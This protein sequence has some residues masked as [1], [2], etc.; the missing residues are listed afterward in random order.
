V[1]WSASNHPAEYYGL[2]MCGSDSTADN[3]CVEWVVNLNT[4]ELDALL[5]PDVILVS[6][7]D[8]NDRAG[9]VRGYIK[10]HGFVVVDRVQAFEIFSRSEQ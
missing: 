10:D 5:P 9:A 1:W 4:D 6:K 8:L 3:E 2:G 7:P